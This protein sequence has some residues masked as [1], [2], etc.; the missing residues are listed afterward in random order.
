[1]GQHLNSCILIFVKTPQPGRVKSRLARTIGEVHATELY[2]RFVLD[3]LERLSDL[4][5]A[6]QIWFTPGEQAARLQEWLG[7]VW[8]YQPQVGAD[9]GARLGHAFQSAFAQGYERVVA[10]GSDSPDLPLVFLQSALLA[11]ENH[12]AVLG[13]SADG[14]Y[15]TIGFR[16]SRF[17][18]AVF[19]DIPWSTKAVLAT[20]LA[21]LRQFQRTLLELPV[22]YDVDTIETLAQFYGQNH[23]HST[24][25][26]QYLRRYRHE[27]FPAFPT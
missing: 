2:K 8:S 10:I 5:C 18:P 20:T 1:M 24:H 11:L 23:Q 25:T 19:E 6:V 13:P 27:I 7:S 26:T 16:A 15:Y 4:D 22:W 3:I 9:L 14:G 17:L 21:R 12:D